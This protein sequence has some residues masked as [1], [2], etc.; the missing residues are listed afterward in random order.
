MIK[1]LAQGKESIHNQRLLLGKLVQSDVILGVQKH[2]FVHLVHQQAQRIVQYGILQ[3]QSQSILCHCR[4]RSIATTTIRS[5]IFTIVGYQLQQLPLFILN[6]RQSL[7]LASI[8]HCPPL[9]HL[10][11]ILLHVPVYQIPP[12]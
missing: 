12:I 8:E 7:T 10:L 5:D 9:L 6:Y 4:S 11:Y 3:P 1:P 2:L